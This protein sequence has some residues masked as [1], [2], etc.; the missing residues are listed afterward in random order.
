M[1]QI[2]LIS[3]IFFTITIVF[4]QKQGNIW[5]FGDKAGISFNSGVP[6]AL[7]NGQL[8]FPNGQNHNEGTSSISDSSGN[9]LFYSDGM[10][11][12]N[13]NHLIMQNG[14]GLLGNFSSTQSSI[15]VPQP[16]QPN[17][18]YFIFTIGSM[19]CCGSSSDGFRYSKIDMCLDGG[20]GGVLPTEKN[21]KLLDTV[22][23]KIA[24]TRHSNGVDYWILT[25]KFNSN[26]FYAMRLTAIG[27]VDT[28][29]SAIGSTHSS[30]F[31][32]WVQGQMKLSP[33]GQKIAV[34]GSGG[35]KLLELFD[36]N[37]TTG[38]VSN[39]MALN[40]IDNGDV[41]GVEFSPDNTK[42]YT[43]SSSYTPFGLDIGQYDLSSGNLSSINASMISLYHNPNPSTSLL[44]GLQLATNGKIYMISN[45]NYGALSVINNP[46]I[47]GFGCDYQAQVVSLG[48][49]LGSLSLPTFISGFDYSNEL[50]QCPSSTSES[51]FENNFSIFP[52]PFSIQTVLQT[53]KQLNNATILIDNV[54]GQTVKQIKYIN[55]QTVL[56]SRENLVSGL[57]FVRLTQDNNIIAIKKIIIAD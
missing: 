13:K 3:I 43:Q 28:V 10:T 52:N 19:F 44:I 29:I 57:Y 26:K 17:R 46:N 45:G 16:D 4:G 6:T 35:L 20:L 38:V 39:F 31:N 36:F 14:T 25:H 32:A 53:S 48:G 22:T 9:I 24:V 41:Y 30:T 54:F 34:G 50:V 40:R 49:R 33:N 37:K 11:I 56:L 21:I 8:T 42:L 1:K 2:L 51:I 47:Y 5:Y 12:W 18:F 23:E 7:F 27:I 55:R 15:I